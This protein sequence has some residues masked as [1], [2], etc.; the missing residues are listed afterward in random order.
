[1]ELFGVTASAG[2]AI[3]YAWIQKAQIKQTGN[4]SIDPAMVDLELERFEFA[5]RDTQDELMTTNVQLID[6]KREIESEMIQTLLELLQDEELLQRVHFK[7]SVDYLQ[8][9]SAVQ[10]AINEI[11]ALV[12]SIDDAYLVERAAEIRDIGR[13]L[14]NHLSGTRKVA[15][16]GYSRKRILL[17]DE[18]AASDSTQLNSQLIIGC[19]AVRG[20]IH[21]HAAII[22]RSIGLPF[23]VGFGE[24]LFR[25]QEGQLIILDSV[26]GKLIVDPS[27]A[28][29]SHYEKLSIGFSVVN[30]AQPILPAKIITLDQHPVQILANIS[31]IACAKLAKSKGAAGIGLFRSEFL[32]LNHEYPPAEQEQF[33]IYH[34]LISVFGDKAPIIIRTFD[35]GG[36]KQ[37][38]FMDPQ[39]AMDS[40]IGDRGIRVSLAHRELFKSQ[41]RAILRA[42]HFGQIK[43]MFPMIAQLSEWEAALSILDEVKKEL[44]AE[45]IAY[46]AN[47]AVGM[48]VE[49]P[50]AAVSMEKFVHVV[51][52]FSIGTNDLIQYLLAADR[53]DTADA[54]VKNEYNP[55]VL[56]LIQH[57]ISVAQKH[58]KWISL[59]GDMAGKPLEAALLLGLGL[60]NF[61]M[62]SKE[63]YPVYKKI[64]QITFL[65]MQKLA[66]RVLEL[67]GTNEVE[68]YLK[69]NC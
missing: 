14:I 20:G 39:A 15:E 34:E 53:S 12:Q 58:G 63:L 22:A 10:E 27:E 37:P 40:F 55:V 21:G 32:Y 13:C 68:S 47:M 16:K 57:I 45:G 56:Q 7:I 33:E 23:I 52:F 36:D 17:T 2:Y 42:S 25:V 24:S 62:D 3:G 44:S 31:T 60:Q 59:C 66:K 35:L 30:E 1:M 43:V 5:L 4:K 8:A 48:M 61:S 28:Q 29:I 51:D 19:A 49:V 18:L 46:N 9:E 64:S 69:N 65:Q 11:D 67:E 26:E 6:K 38:R 50:E 54:N 41:L